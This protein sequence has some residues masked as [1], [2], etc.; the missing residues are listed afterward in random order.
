MNASEQRRRSDSAGKAKK[1]QPI[2]NSDDQLTTGLP[3]NLDAERFVLGA[4]LLDDARFGEVSRLELEDFSLDRHQSVLRRMRDLHA[5]GEHIDRVTV[6]EELRRHNE[7]GR[8]GISFLMS[9]DEGIPQIPHLDSYVRILRK[10]AALRRGVLISQKFMNECLMEC[11]DPAEIV[12]GHKA[13]IEELTAAA[14]PDQTAIR[15]IED[16]DSIFA[17]RMPTEYLIKPE[18]PVKAVV[19]LTGDSES[20]KTTLACAWARDVHRRGHAVLVLDRDKNPRD[21]ICDRLERL[22]INSDGELFRVWDCEQPEE[23]PQPDDPIITDWVK[24]MIA[25][26]GKS[27]VVI[28]D[29]LVSFFVGDEDENSAVDMR[30]LFNRCRALTKLGATVIVIHHTNRNGEA[31][32]SSDFKPASDQAFLVSNH[33]GDGGRLLDLITLRCEKSRYGLSGKIEY[34][35]DGGQMRRIEAESAPSKTVTERLRDLLISNPGILTQPFVDL[36]NED[37][38]GRNRARD[39][40][41]SAVEK[42]TVRVQRE[43]RKRHHFWRGAEAPADDF[44]PQPPLN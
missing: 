30:R 15:C 10:K 44:D 3:V 33:D 41:N 32:G 14:A 16:L 31:R 13:Q 25:T 29:S 4:V 20:G 2:T 27:P 43:G 22:G 11:A 6:A 7:L 34:R 8:D 17:K 1:V 36:A 35:Y 9:L 18:L 24:R 38:L 26:T 28:V 42:G 40:L 5:R 21:R 39:F 23:A 12:A 37:G 19:C